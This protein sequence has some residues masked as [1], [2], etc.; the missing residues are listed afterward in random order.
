ML[1]LLGN[2]EQCD[3]LGRSCCACGHT[4]SRLSVLQIGH[5]CTQ[6]LTLMSWTSTRVVLDS[7]QLSLPSCVTVLLRRTTRDGCGVVGDQ[8]AGSSLSLLLL[9]VGANATTGMSAAG[10]VSAHVDL[11]VFRSTS[12]VAKMKAAENF[13]VRAMACRCCG[14]YSTQA[15]NFCLAAQPSHARYALSA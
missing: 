4:P 8:F 10:S 11:E 13:I 12:I 5:P 9:S 15:R 1:V 7:R 2:T 3:P 6:K 14:K